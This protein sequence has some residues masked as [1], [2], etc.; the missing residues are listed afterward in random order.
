MGKISVRW[1]PP[2]SGGTLARRHP[3]PRALST[4]RWR[5]Q[6]HRAVVRCT[7]PFPHRHR[8]HRLRAGV[9]CT[10]LDLQR[11]MRSTRFAPPPFALHPCPPHSRHVQPNQPAT[12]KLRRAACFQANA[13]PTQPNQ[14]P[15]MGQRAPLSTH[16]VNSNIPG[17]SEGL[18]LALTL[19][20]TLTVAL[21]VTVTITV[22]ATATATLTPTR[23]RTRTRTRTLTLTLA[24]PLTKATG[25][26]RRS[27]CSSTRCAGR[28]TVS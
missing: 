3:H 2:S 16:R 20:V 12:L 26:T 23:T 5:P 6:A 8:A 21:T 17:P 27:R 13:M 4:S 25:S 24:L 9:R 7:R 15:A 19:T 11:S 14:Q 28:A 1:L 10:R 22:T 18:T